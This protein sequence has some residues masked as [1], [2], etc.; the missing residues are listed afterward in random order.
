[1]KKILTNLGITVTAVFL[2][3]TL[4]LYN[5]T[6]QSSITAFNGE[7]MFISWAH[8]NEYNVNKEKNISFYGGSDDVYLPW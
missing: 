8:S 5:N 4:S 6:K 7:G 2:F 3:L 1:M